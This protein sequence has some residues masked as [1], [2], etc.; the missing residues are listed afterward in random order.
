V[1]T[2]PY[3][4][5]AIPSF[6][7]EAKRLAKKYRSLKNDLQGLNDQLRLEPALA[8][9]PLGGNSYKI[10]LAVKSKKKGKSGGA[11]VII[12]IVSADNEVYLL[13]IYDKSDLHDQ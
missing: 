6:K 11:R 5:I 4:I 13:T 10:R 1:T 2:N 9:T 7:K 12:Y 3:T 8:G